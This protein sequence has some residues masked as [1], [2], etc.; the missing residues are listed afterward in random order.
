MDARDWAGAV[1]AIGRH[2][3]TAPVAVVLDAAYSA[4]GPGGRMDAPLAALEPVADRALVLTAWS[5]SKTFTH[6]GLRVGAL[7]ALVPDDAERKQVAAALTYACRGAWSNCNRGGMAAIAR[8]LTE[9]ALRDAC[10]A[11]RDELVRLLRTRV[12]TFNRAAKAA[13]LTYPRY[14]GGFFTTVFVDDGAAVAAK[15]RAEGVYVV[16]QGRGVRLALCSTAT[17]EVARLV[18]VL[19]RASR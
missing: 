15:M 19:A 12:E 9:P 8:C 13:G 5:A 2:A 1:E 7:V 10:A 14:D 16:P 6:Y 11:E 4:Y 17:S 18:D 3:A